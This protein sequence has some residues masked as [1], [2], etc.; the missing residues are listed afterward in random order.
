MNPND[1]RIVR[2]YV[3]Q[4]GTLVQDEAPNNND[5]VAAT[6]FDVVFEGEA[7]HVI[8]KSGVPYSLSLVCY[9]LTAGANVAAFAISR[10]QSFSNPP[11]TASGLE[12]VSHQ[13]FP[14]NVPAGLSGHVLRYTASLLT[15]GREVVA[16]AQSEL[17]IL[18]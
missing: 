5:G 2:L 7:G 3:A 10:N 13:V 8:G 14:V 6:A 4:T 18:I 12:Y 1:A 16:F 15:Q 17:F 9:D 11:W